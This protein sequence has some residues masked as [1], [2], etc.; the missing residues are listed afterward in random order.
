MK[1]LLTGKNGQVG[2]ELNRT[3]LPL[4]EVIALDRT[5]ADLS[6]PEQLRSI[7]QEI[8][9]SVIVNAAA[10]TAVDK[11]ESEEELATVINATSPG[12]IAEEAKKINALLVHFSTDYVFDGSK[13]S[14]YTEED[15]PNPINAYGR[16]KLSGEEALI[17]FST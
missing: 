12:V 8:K 11:A 14:A 16:T 3:L 10:Y 4:G 5:G 1:I 13:D 6:K 7:V 2:W 15:L 17:L 9:P